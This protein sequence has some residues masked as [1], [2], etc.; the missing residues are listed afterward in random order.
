MAAAVWPEDED[1]SCFDSNFN[2][3]NI[4]VDAGMR[5]TRDEEW[6]RVRGGTRDVNVDV[7][8]RHSLHVTSGDTRGH[9]LY[10]VC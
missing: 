5:E 1:W 4:R 8:Q 10:Q 6:G 3:V 7:I 9:K 2:V